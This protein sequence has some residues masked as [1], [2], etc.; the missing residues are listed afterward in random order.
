LADYFRTPVAVHVFLLRTDEILMLQRRNTGFEDGN[1]SVVGGHLD[2]G[3][4]IVAAAVREAREEAGIGIAAD[5]VCVAGVMHRRTPEQE[6]IDFFVTVRRWAG[7]ITN[8]EPHKC[9]DL[10]WFP[11]EQLPA[12]TIPYVRQAIANVL[13]GQWFDSWG[14][15]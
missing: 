8:C 7:E 14:W 5:D 2:G 11:L 1:Y 3:E 13:A 15:D 9:S 10:S 4:T 12:N 6:R